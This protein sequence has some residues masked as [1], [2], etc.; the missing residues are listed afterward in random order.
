MEISKS[1]RN[2]ISTYSED[3]DKNNFN[4]LYHNILLKEIADSRN[5]SWAADI[6]QFTSILYNIWN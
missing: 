3:I 2:L 4:K 1:L 5:D 6:G